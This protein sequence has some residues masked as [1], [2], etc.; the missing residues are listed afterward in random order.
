[1]NGWVAYEWRAGDMGELCIWK[2]VVWVGGREWVGG[3]D[4][5]WIHDGQEIES[6]AKSRRIRGGQAEGRAN[7]SC[8]GWV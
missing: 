8:P 7:L 4:R 1:M 6:E 5:R 2:D 3:L